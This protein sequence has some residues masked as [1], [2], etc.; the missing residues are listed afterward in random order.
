MSICSDELLGRECT[1]ADHRSS[2]VGQVPGL[3]GRHPISAR[4]FRC[5]ASR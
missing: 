4:G 5:L 3:L 1:S 2:V